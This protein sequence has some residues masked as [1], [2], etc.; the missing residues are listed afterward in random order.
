VADPDVAGG[1]GGHPQQADQGAGDDQVAREAARLPCRQLGTEPGGDLA[2]IA[3]LGGRGGGGL[4]RGVARRAV[5]VG[6][7][8]EPA[9]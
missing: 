2:G 6:R 1:G 8:E 7:V 4:V 9:A 5:G 3:E